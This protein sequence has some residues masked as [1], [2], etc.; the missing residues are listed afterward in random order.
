MITFAYLMF[1]FFHFCR[2]YLQDEITNLT[3]KSL[4]RLF[5]LWTMIGFKS[6]R[7]DRSEVALGHVKGI[8]DT[9]IAEEERNLDHI[10]KSIKKYDRERVELYKDLGESYNVDASEADLPLVDVGA[11]IKAEVAELQERKEKRMEV[12]NDVRKAEKTLCDA[13]GSVPLN[14]MFERMPTDV[15][16][17]QIEKHVVQLKVSHFSTMWNFQDFLRLRFYVKLILKSSKTAIFVIL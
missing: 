3:S 1:H 14:V 5:E 12:Y 15:H 7:H 16:V 13:T 6:I 9:M 17:K 10:T 4:D 11:K 8:F 2:D